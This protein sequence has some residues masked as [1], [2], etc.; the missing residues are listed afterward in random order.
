MYKLSHLVFKVILSETRP[1]QRLQFLKLTY[2]T[3]KKYMEYVCS[4]NL[5]AEK[6][7]ELRSQSVK[8]FERWFF[9]QIFDDFQSDRDNQR[10]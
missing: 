3:T 5:A 10:F 4:K 9:F 2:A 7:F 1:S 6:C 8:L